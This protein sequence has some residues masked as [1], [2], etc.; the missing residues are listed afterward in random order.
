MTDQYE[1]VTASDLKPGD[2]VEVVFSGI[3]KDDGLHIGSYG[4]E[5]IPIMFRADDAH[6][7]RRKSRPI[8]V[9]DRVTDEIAE[10]GTVEG[11]MGKWAWVRWHNES[12]GFS[13]QPVSDLT[14][15]TP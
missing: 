12:F 2:E 7:I 4:R 8:S 10:I 9:G 3:V 5:N 6:T 11:V 1:P 14:R 13:T 15:V